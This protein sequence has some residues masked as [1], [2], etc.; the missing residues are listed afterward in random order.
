MQGRLYLESTH[1][2]GSTF[3]LE[4]PRVDSQQ[5][6]LL[7]A[8]QKIDAAAA[9]RQAAATPA[10][11]VPAMP[12]VVTPRP[13]YTPIQPAVTS[14]ASGPVIAPVPAD[15][16]VKAATTVPRGEALSREQIAEHV[17]KLEAMVRAQNGVAPRPPEPP[18]PGQA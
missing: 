11:V 5:A 4:L 16:P 15:A 14:T 17:R 9:A 10:P 13:V 2:Q 12:P 3:F 6:E 1:G 8:Q 18:A 7:K